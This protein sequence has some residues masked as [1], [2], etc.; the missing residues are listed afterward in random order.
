M[1]WHTNLGAMWR[2]GLSLM[3]GATAAG[4]GWAQPSG[5]PPSVQ[6]FFSPAKLQDAELSPSGRWMAALTGA[7]GRRVGFQMI[8]LEGK[9]APRFIEA[10]PKDNVAWFQWVSDD[11]LVF[12][13]N[14][15]DDR[16]ANRRRGGLVALKRDGSSSRLLINREYEKEDALQRRRYLDPN[17]FYMT[18]GAPNKNE[19]IIGEAHWDVSGDFSH[20]TPKVLD[21]TTG[22]V[23]T[24]LSDA[25]RADS[26]LFDFQ[27]QARVASY[28]KEG[29]TTRWWA[30]ADGKWAE[31]SKAPTH[32]QAFI[33][34]HVDGDGTLV[35]T[36]A[37]RDGYMELRRFDFATGK[38]GSTPIVKTPGF[39]S[40]VGV[41][42]READTGMV[43]GLSVATDARSIVWL[44]PVMQQ[45]QQKVDAKF[46]NS[47]N[48]IYCKRCE[49]AK[50][51]LVF[52]RSDHEPGTYVL[53]SP[54]ANKWQLLGEAKPE[55]QPEKMAA[56]DFH[57][58][59]ARDGQDLPVWVTRPLESTGSAPKAGPQPAVIVVHGGPF[60]RG[61]EW[62]WR[63]E[64][65]FLASRGYVVIEPEF[66]GSRGYGT[67]HYRAGWKQWG[68]AMQ[69][70]VTDAL[71]FAVKSG[72]VDP[73]RV[74]IMGF[75]YGGYST[76]MGLIRDPALY[77]CGIAGGAVSDLRYLYDFYWSDQEDE[78]RRYDLPLVMGDR[79]KDADMLAAASA[80]DQAEK[81]N[82]PLLLVH[83]ARDRRVP[84]EHAEKMLAALRKAGKQVE[85]VRYAEEGHGFFYDENR[86]DYYTK[87]E[88]FLAKHLKR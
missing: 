49:T 15:P 10:S 78:G 30:G 82:A 83:G 3:V 34:S 27:G 53:W 47:Q 52:T 28:T 23:R 6:S 13:V 72:W 54:Q 48:F 42:A 43:Q 39:Y 16:S 40:G 73:K 20:V 56:L 45:L 58:T 64:S 4:T 87:I 33:P 44:S 71:A 55:I 81:I 69:D 8:D 79:K 65:Q 9:E 12:G 84:I 17:H 60:S 21:V 85:W 36:T 32:D 51:V 11:W 46:P 2:I 37:D 29:I 59:K 75:S 62:R 35:V 41:A 38:P 57:R 1:N 76:F 70:D 61:V 25:P 24:L 26:W 63:A 74:C 18:L 88:Q 67:E 5:A 86:F 68:R 31:I 19:V 50:S 7:P 22:V 14:S 66:R 77:Q 80:V